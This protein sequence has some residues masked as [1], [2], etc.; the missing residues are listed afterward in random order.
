M[1]PFEYIRNQIV[2]AFNT[3]NEIGAK[4]YFLCKLR[5]N[6]LDF[7]GNM[8]YNVGKYVIKCQK[9]LDTRKRWTTSV[10]WI[11]KEIERM[12]FGQF[13]HNIDAKGRLT[14]PSSFREQAPEG[15]FLTNGFDANLIAYPKPYY[16]RIAETLSALSITDPQSRALRRLIFAHTAE[17]NYD[18][19]GRILIPSYLREIAKMNS[20]VMMVGIG[21]SF[22]LW[23]A[24]KWSEQTVTMQDPEANSNRWASIDISTRGH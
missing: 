8:P 16:E 23:S 4:S 11:K 21:D 5:A 20:S 2:F 14:V 3:I 22:E 10:S 12:F 15:I 9:V 13:E 24:E 6:T 7:L 17:L 19:A 18:T 1:P